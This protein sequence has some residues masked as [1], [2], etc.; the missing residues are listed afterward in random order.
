MA[1]QSCLDLRT[2]RPPPPSMMMPATPE[3]TNS[4][5]HFTGAA[6][7]LC[8]R[9][10]RA[11]SRRRPMAVSVPPVDTSRKPSKSRRGL[12][13]VNNLIVA[14][15]ELYPNLSPD[16]KWEDSSSMTQTVDRKDQSRVELSLHQYLGTQVV[17]SWPASQWNSKELSLSSR[18]KLCHESIQRM[19][20]ERERMARDC[21]WARPLE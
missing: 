4:A 7:S 9:P 5:D 13:P 12:S 18:S 1:R 16:V 10:T 6:R 11:T 17:L 21:V 3:M 15:R 19:V 2:R 20:P 14:P 8:P